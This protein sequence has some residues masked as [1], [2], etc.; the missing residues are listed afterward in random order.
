MNKAAEDNFIVTREYK[1]FAEFCDACRRYRYIGLCYGPP[2]VGKTLSARHYARWDKVES[3]QSFKT[4]AALLDEVLGCD[5]VFYTPNVLNGPSRIAQEI[6]RLRLRLLA[7]ARGALYREEESVRACARQRH[8]EYWNTFVYTSDWLS[9]PPQ[10][11]REE[12]AP[13]LYEI[14][15]E[16]GA[17]R[18][19]IADPTQLILVDEAERLK[20]ASLEQMR[21]LFDQ[22][23]IGLVLI[24]M[25][26]LEKRLARYPQ[27]YS[28]VGFVHEFRT[29]SAE[30]V[31]Q[32]LLQSW[33][34]PKTVLPEQSLTDE[35]A[36]AAIIRITGGNFRL[37]HRLLTQIAR[38]MEINAMQT[39][40][41]QVVETAR[42]NLVIGT[43]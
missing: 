28:R 16:Y 15:Q 39:I 5:T 32:L 12:P 23:D 10:S 27:L 38:L 13:S 21:A 41:R 43:T 24:G 33:T 17:K 2:G 29:L 37:L 18:D 35:E 14:A 9:E 26:G 25:P 34:P 4:S 36:L 30:E 40:T 7:I 22:G 1:R 42:E 19:A 20:M 11:R 31:R 8:E 6:A 3:Y